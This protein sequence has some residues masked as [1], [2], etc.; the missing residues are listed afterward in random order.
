M[1]FGFFSPLYRLCV[2]AQRFAVDHLSTIEFVLDDLTKAFGIHGNLSE[3]QQ[4]IQ[5]TIVDADDS[6]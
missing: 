1:G 2:Y 4:R 6:T 5:F 3:R